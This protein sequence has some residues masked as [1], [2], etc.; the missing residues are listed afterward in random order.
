MVVDDSAVVRQVLQEILKKHPD[1]TVIGV[2]PDP[3]FA[4]ARMQQ[5]WPDVLVLDVEMPRMD[6]I[7]FLRQIMKERPTPTVICSS[8]TEQGM[9]TTLDALAAGAV[10]IITK[11][12]AGVSGFLRNSEQEFVSAIRAAA[13]S[14]V[15][16]LQASP[17]L[18]KL[19]ADAVLAAPASGKALARTTERFVA[20][21]ISTGGTQAL[22]FVL[23]SLPRTA[24][25]IVIVQHMPQA[26]TRGFAERLDGICSVQVK[27][28]E[29]GDR[30]LPGRALIAPG[31]RHTLVKRS[32][33]QYVAD[34]I[35]G[36]LV[37][38]HRPSADVL[39]RSVAGS[40]GPNAM[41]IIMTGMGDDG[42]RGL[43]EMFDAGAQTIAQDEQSCVVFGMPKEAIKHGGVREVQSLQSIPE[44]IVRYG[45]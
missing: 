44:L 16:R 6:G 7:S 2:A 4:L 17:V 33:A 19:T 29:A 27:E 43:K 39:F 14:N 41:G 12:M 36:P 23:S 31:G 28:A 18:A 20:I 34:V 30:I 45:R 32:G 3:I 5:A 24:P 21:G 38:R 40:A 9:Q 8:L 35:D 22:E 1:I 10:S 15:R 37:S 25:G 13:V 11:P 42:A 26:F